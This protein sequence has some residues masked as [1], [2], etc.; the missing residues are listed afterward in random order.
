MPLERLCCLF[1]HMFVGLL[2]QLRLELAIEQ[3]R[4]ELA[5]SGAS[6]LPPRAVLERTR[7]RP[8]A[9]DDALHA[10][11]PALQQSDPGPVAIATQR[12]SEIRRVPEQ[13]DDSLAHPDAR[14]E[15]KPARDEDLARPSARFEPRSARS[16]Q[17]ATAGKPA[18]VDAFLAGLGGTAEP[19][20]AATDSA[21]EVRSRYV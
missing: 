1:A 7:Q 11:A 13:I 9:Q 20:L 16:T 6:G 10:L 4:A 15:P 2:E 14:F 19:R 5:N 3:L 17:Q 8:T 21:K 12:L 18:W